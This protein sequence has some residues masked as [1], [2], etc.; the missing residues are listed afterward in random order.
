MQQDVCQPKFEGG[1]CGEDI[2]RV[3]VRSDDTSRADSMLMRNVGKEPCRLK[4][5][6]SHNVYDPQFIF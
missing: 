3:N 4:L 6:E 2:Q 1:D 5:L